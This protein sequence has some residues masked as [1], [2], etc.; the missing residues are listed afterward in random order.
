MGFARNRLIILMEDR[1]EPFHLVFD[2]TS[3]CV[4]IYEYLARVV[5]FM[6]SHI[7]SDDKEDV[8]PPDT[9]PVTSLQR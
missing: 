4:E 3:I 7:R 9:I 8:C 1:K 5:G 6:A 2:K